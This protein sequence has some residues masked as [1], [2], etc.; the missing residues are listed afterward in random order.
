M[1]EKI[2]SILSTNLFH[3]TK[4]READSWSMSYSMIQVIYVAFIWSSMSN[5]YIT[6]KPLVKVAPNPEV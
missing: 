2:Y 4:G 5:G 1:S 3:K 6:V